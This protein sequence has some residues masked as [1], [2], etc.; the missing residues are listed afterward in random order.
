MT[1]ASPL[2]H[3]AFTLPRVGED[4]PLR[5]AFRRTFVWSSVLA[6]LGNALLAAGLLSLS[7][8]PREAERRPTAIRFQVD[9]VP[10]FHRTRWIDPPS[11]AGP[12]GQFRYGEIMPVPDYDPRELA[13]LGDDGVSLVATAGLTALTEGGG[14]TTAGPPGGGGPAPADGYELWEKAPAL[15]SIP[16]PEYPS[17]ARSAGVEGVVLLLILVGEDGSAREVRVSEGPDLLHEAAIAAAKQA[18]FR[19]ALTQQ[20]PVAA[21][22]RLPLKF[23]LSS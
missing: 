3:A 17:I 10:E 19:P 6:M 12:L 5:R 18:R 11:A 7:D 13:L 23:T 4:H 22:V 15:I 14:E 9:P 8:L 1:H 2:P 20:R 16:K 21:W